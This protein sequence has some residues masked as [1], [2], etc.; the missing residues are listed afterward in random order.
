MST[1]TLGVTTG[2]AD[3]FNYQV[4][5]PLS[6]QVSQLVSLANQFKMLYGQIANG[7]NTS[8][9]VPTKFYLATRTITISSSTLDIDLTLLVDIFGNV[10]NFSKIY[11]MVLHNNDASGGSGV[12]IKPGAS[13]GW[14][15]PWNG[16]S[17]GQNLLDAGGDFVISSPYKGIN[18]N[19]GSKILRLQNDAASPTGP[20]S[21]TMAIAGG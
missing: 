2:V 11:R 12:I 13:N 18:V 7:A 17:S 21:V 16:S 8:I 9:V 14:V 6:D 1:P 10:L 19:A 20:N 5:D 15:G 4:A 3:S